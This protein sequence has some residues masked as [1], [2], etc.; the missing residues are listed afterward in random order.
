MRNKIFL[1][2]LIFSISLISFASVIVIYNGAGFFE[3]SVSLSKMATISVPNTVL[4]N[5]FYTDPE[6]KIAFIP[7]KNIDLESILS[8]NKFIYLNHVKYEVVSVKPIILK[9]GSDYVYNPDMKGFSFSSVP[10]RE[11]PKFAIT[12]SF[13]KLRYSYLF[14]G[15]SYKLKYIFNDGRITSFLELKNTTDYDFK[16][17]TVYIATQ[18]IKASES[19]N[20]ERVLLKSSSLKYSPEKAGE[21]YVYK[22]GKLDL[23]ANSYF[24]IPFVSDKVKYT[25]YYKYYPTSVLSELEAVISFKTSKL[26]PAGEWIVAEKS[27]D[28]VLFSSPVSLGNF[29][30][31]ENVELEYGFSYDLKG[32]ETILKSVRNGKIYYKTFKDTVYN[33]K[34]K[35]VTVKIYKS[36][37]NAVL[38]DYKGKYERK[39]TF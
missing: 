18:K 28:L 17:S 22:V 24:K 16:N 27:K 34:D 37:R 26:L 23:P 10:L 38:Q 6:S 5:S 8:A 25:T 31:Q 14:K 11:N 30:K 2:L 36:A 9:S 4:P 13:K 21:N 15:I 39:A 32:M 20:S 33:H 29:S 1:L 7:A 12:S 35:A 3:G 19:L